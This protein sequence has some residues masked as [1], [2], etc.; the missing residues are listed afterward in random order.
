MCALSVKQ[1][2]DNLGDV[3]IYVRDGGR[4][5]I[6]NRFKLPFVKYLGLGAE[7]VILHRV[8]NIL[9]SYFD[10]VVYIHNVN[11]YNSN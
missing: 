5:N 10:S 8:S 11:L 6:V 2:V 1:N 4:M 7:R 9:N 3:D